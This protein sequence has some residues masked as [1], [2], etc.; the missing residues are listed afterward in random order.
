MFKFLSTVKI[1]I[2]IKCGRSDHLESALLFN[3]ARF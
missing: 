2:S 1:C 3:L